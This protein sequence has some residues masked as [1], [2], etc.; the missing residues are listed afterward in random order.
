MSAG[1]LWEATAP[2]ARERAPLPG[3]RDADVAVIGGGLTGLWT[4]WYLL[5][6]D[7]GIRVV[8]LEAETVGFGASGRNGGWASALF[9]QST[10]AL[11]RRHGREQAIRMRRAMLETVDE[12]ARAA[13]EAG[14]D[15]DY[16]K[17]GTITYARDGAQLAAARA[18]QQADAAYGVDEVELW[19]A[20]RVRAAGT[21][22]GT[23]ALGAAYDPACARVHPLRLVRGL[24]DAVERAGVTVHERTRV[25]DWAPGRVRT[26]RGTVTAE[27]VVIATE[28]YTA[29]F[30]AAHRRLLPL[31]SLMIATEPLSDAVWDE[32]GIGHGQTFADY[33]HLIVYGQRT[34]DNRIAFGGRGAP[35]HL[36]SRIRPD[37]DRSAPVARHLERALH[38][39]FP[40]LPAVAVTHAWGG[41][42]GVPRDWHPSVRFDPTTGIAWAGGYVGDGLAT[43]NLA[44]RTL[45]DLITG[46]ASDLV[47]LPWVGH[48]SPDWEAEPLRWLG[49]NAGTTAMAVADAEERLTGRP[50]LVARAFAPLIGH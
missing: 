7:P 28:A 49:A 23:G 44:G 41:P 30:R 12:V 5:H 42:L 34:A 48:R 47:D 22:P 9:P 3:D 36:G 39:L 6:R 11:A 18:D 24:A 29:G 40:Q 26:D 21:R 15:F 8:M 35:Y 32:L 43:T 17:G 20:D 27:R 45:A 13:G 19:A 46:T 1:S 25:L 37:Y 31:Y 33:R 50:S 14:I 2:P 4:A 16:A 38:D 10:A